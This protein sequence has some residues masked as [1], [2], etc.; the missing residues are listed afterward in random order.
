M[1]LPMIDLAA[2]PNLDQVTGLFGSLSQYA[3]G[4]TD[5]RIVIMMVYLYELMPPQS[6]L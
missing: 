6:L 2:L 1:N 5:D 3:D 4:Y